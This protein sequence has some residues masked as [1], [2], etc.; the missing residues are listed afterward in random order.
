MLYCVVLS[1]FVLLLCVCVYLNVFVY[2]VCDVLFGVVWFGCCRMSGL[3][4]CVCL[5]CV[6]VLFRR[7]CLVL[8]VRLNCCLMLC[9]Y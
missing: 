3:C 8:Y 1:A 5:K 7:C 4:L 6:C 2:V 9:A